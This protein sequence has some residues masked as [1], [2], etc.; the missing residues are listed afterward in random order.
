MADYNYL[1]NDIIAATENTGT[2]FLNYIPY[3]V[4]H[5]EERLVK[6]LDDYGLVQYVSVALSSGVNNLT[7]PTGTRVVKNLNF[8]NENGSKINLLLRTDEFINDYWP[9]SASVGIPKYYARRT[10]DSVLLA[11]TPVSTY[12]GTAVVV[13]RPTTLTSATP[14]NY[15]TDYCYDL[16]FNACMAEATMFQKDY[17]A[18]QQ[19]EGRYRT[20]LELQRNQA[21]RTRRDD[22]QTPASPAGGD[23]TLIP[24]SN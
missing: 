24:N 10:N 11:P 9:V 17:A 5:S 20:L 16:L 21:R 12:D 23:D 22:M 7:L 4:N 18:M 8:N 1:V 14:N 13:V 19:F 3:M 15:F 6:D 2:E